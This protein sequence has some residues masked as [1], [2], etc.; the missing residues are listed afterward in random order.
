MF[1]D[2]CAL[3]G[4]ALDGHSR[5]QQ[6]A[7]F[8]RSKS[9]GTALA[10]LRDVM[11]SNSFDVF[12]TRFDHRTRQD[13]FHVLNDWDG[14]ADHVNPNTIPVDVLDYIARQRGGEAPD[15]RALAMLLDYYYFHILQ[16]LSL[17][18][19]DDGD[20]D[21]NLDRLTTLLD[22]LQGPNG[23]G[24]RFVT[25]A[26]TLI[27]IATSHFEVVERGY[28]K[29]LRR[30]KT[31]NRA[32]QTN[33]ALGHASSMGSHL[34]FGFEATYARDT[35]SMREDNVADYPWLCFALGTLMRA[36][37]AASGSKPE[38]PR[39]LQPEEAP[40][41]EPAGARAVQP[42]GAPVSE[43]A[44]A[45]AFQTEEAPVFEPEGARAFQASGA[46]IVEAMA[47][48]LSP[49][50]R[51]FIGAAPPSLSR[52]DAERAAFRDAFLAHRSD[53]LA[54]FERHRPV[55]G[56]YSPLSFFFNFSHNVL[57]GTIV[58]AL[59]RGEPWPVAFNDMLTG[60]PLVRPEADAIDER[61]PLARRLMDYARE[62]PDRIGGRLMPVIVYDPRAGHRAFRVMM[63]KLAP[64]P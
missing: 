33:V 18:I 5:Q 46:A 52:A 21:E 6:I 15:P 28:D 59:L 37:V 31:L 17:R 58:D 45:R 43:P 9:F 30:V 26:D 12:V 41:S 49:D 55:E 32:H 51:A 42:E 16:L 39:A 63:E 10:R 53:L 35:T 56:T 8:A 13:G 50:A 23:S 2:A 29:L 40:V 62:N 36:Y 61:E 22:A 60:L 48:G 25:N 38:G 14:K 1:A 54:E 11:R 64:S 4:T 44:G 57:K 7:D 3:I 34:R 24:Q 19:W 47:N 27:L 20:A